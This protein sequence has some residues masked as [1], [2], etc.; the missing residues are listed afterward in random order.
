MS[1]EDYNVDE[2][3]TASQIE[4]EYGVKHNTVNKWI[5]AKRIPARKEFN[6]LGMEYYKVRRGDFDTFLR[7]RSKR[8]RPLILG[9]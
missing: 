1:G 7:S 6:E 9:G 2:E 8:G 4:E 3:L 5:R